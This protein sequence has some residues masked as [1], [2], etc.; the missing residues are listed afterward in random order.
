MKIAVVGGGIS[1]LGTAWL[2]ARQHEVSLFESAQYLGGHSNTVDILLGGR[3]VPIDTGFIVYNEHN[4]PN[5]T[6]LFAALG[7]KTAASDM[8]FS[9]SLDG[10]GFEYFGT[11]EY[12]APEQCTCDE[13]SIGPATDLYA[14]GIL[15]YEMLSGRPP[16]D[17]PSTT[18]I[19]RDQVRGRAIPVETL[20]R[21]VPPGLALLVRSLLQKQTMRRPQ[22]ADAVSLEL[23]RIHGAYF[24]TAPAA[25]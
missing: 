7:V 12:S 5:L 25:S 16:F 9:V 19:L 23:D 14:L 20:R 1:G 3:V 18:R 6:R 24:T 8:S 15:I 22:R 4:Y 2:L 11:P 13:R 21:G 10:G 17:D